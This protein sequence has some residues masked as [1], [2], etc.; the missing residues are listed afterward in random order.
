MIKC[1]SQSYPE[2]SNH[3]INAFSDPRSV[4]G[5][6]APSAWARWIKTETGRRMIF[7]ANMLNFYSSH[8]HSTGKQL[9]YYEPLDDELILN[10]PLPCS[11][12]AWLAQNEEDWRSAMQNPSSPLASGHLSGFN[13]P[14]DEAL[15]SET[16]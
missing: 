14:E 12:D 13:S 4:L 16:S 11:Q 5:G 9:P 1:Y 10:M 3:N 15:S 2:I 7:L 6:T 8:D